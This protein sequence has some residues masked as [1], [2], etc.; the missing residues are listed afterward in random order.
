[1]NKTIGV[2]IVTY[3]SER[4]LSKC[5]DALAANTRN[6]DYVVIVDSGSNSQEYLQY[7][8]RLA[9]LEVIVSAINIGYAAANNIGFSYLRDKADYVLFLNPDVFCAPEA[10]HRAYSFMEKTDTGDIG[11]I[12][13][14][15]L[16]YDV[17]QSSPTGLIDSTGIFHT[18]YGRFYD[19]GHGLPET[20]NKD[21][22]VE[23][24]PAACGAFL[25]CR[26]GAIQ[27]I[28]IN[29][30]QVFD[31]SFFMYKEDIDFSLRLQKTGYRVLYVPQ[32]TAYH[33]R[34]WDTNRKRVPYWARRLSLH[35]DW[36]LWKKQYLPFTQQ[37]KFLLYLLVKIIYLYSFEQLR[38][39]NNDKGR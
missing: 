25:F 23:E 24:I 11:M 5:M 26:T 34:G 1:M 18:S 7:K 35:N 17:L 2:V 28:L 31:E 16:G 13:G 10:L 32:I 20:V 33:C 6:P 30:R 8:N 39:K 14:K 38:E 3:N 19:R 36:R 22:R 27:D 9:N 37:V 29:G 4:Y 21:S 15:L 12:T